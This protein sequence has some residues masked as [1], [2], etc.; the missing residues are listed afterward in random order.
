MKITPTSQVGAVEG[1][2]S[3]RKVEPV[4]EGASSKREGEAP[5][6][7][8][9]VILPGGHA[10]EKAAELSIGSKAHAAGVSGMIETY[11]RIRIAEDSRTIMIQIVNAANGEV[12]REIPPGAWERLKHSEP[13]PKSEAG[14]KED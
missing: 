1:A 14:D 6:P 13:T 3:V 2:A 9:P 7:K 8:P 4:V 11:A 12:I 5:A 10:G